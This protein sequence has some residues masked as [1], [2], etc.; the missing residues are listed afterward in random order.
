VNVVKVFL[1]IR[2]LENDRFSSSGERG[3]A[4]SYEKFLL[5]RQS[6]PEES[7]RKVRQCRKRDRHDNV[8][9]MQ[10]LISRSSVNDFPLCLIEGKVE[11][12][13]NI[14]DETMAQRWNVVDR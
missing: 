7:E 10:A 8:E 6:R 13:G 14:P 11:V 1:A 5:K 3:N 2:N 12:M 9:D 4:V